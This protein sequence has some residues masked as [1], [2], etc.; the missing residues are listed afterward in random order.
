[1]GQPLGEVLAPPNAMEG[2]SATP[3]LPLPPG[4]SALRARRSQ[5]GSRSSP[6][7]IAQS[8]IRPMGGSRDPLN[9]RDK[10]KKPQD[11]TRDPAA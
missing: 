7:H 6:L 9:R 8:I 5:A 1:M 4:D 3:T 11:P 2:S 10:R